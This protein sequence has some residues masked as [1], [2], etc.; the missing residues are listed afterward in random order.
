LRDNGTAVASDGRQRSTADMRKAKPKPPSVI[1]LLKQDH[2]YVKA[3]YRRF[4]KMDHEDLAAVEGVVSEVCTALEV[5]ARVEEEIFYPAVRKAIDDDDLMEEAEIEHESAK[6]LI[7][8]LK[9]MKLSAAAY[10]PTFTVLCE[11]VMHHVKEEE[12]EM[13]P[14]VQ[15]RK[16]NLQALGKKVM[17]RKIRLSRRA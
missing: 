12:S 1:E 11:Y 6:T 2:E 9:R 13:F 8:R 14:K 16:L 3:A 15:R 10:V 7:R 17:E 4:E 5:H